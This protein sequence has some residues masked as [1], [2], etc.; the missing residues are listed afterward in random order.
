MLRGGVHLADVVFHIRSVHA[1]AHDIQP[2]ENAGLGVIDRA[3]F[4]GFEVA[5]PGATGVHGRGDAAR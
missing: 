3:G 4:E 5:M 2:G 1:R